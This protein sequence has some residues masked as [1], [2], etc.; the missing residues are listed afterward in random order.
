MSP[1]CN[2]GASKQHHVWVG[3]QD[4]DKDL[5]GSDYPSVENSISKSVVRNC[6]PGSLPPA[7]RQ[8]TAAP[9]HP[10]VKRMAFQIVCF[11]ACHPN[12]P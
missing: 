11:R 6:T 8:M 3:V 12:K 5:P 2:F 7:G 10:G 4:Q 9:A 1:A